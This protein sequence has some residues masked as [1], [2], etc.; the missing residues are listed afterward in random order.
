MQ[1]KYSIVL[2]CYNEFKN[3]RLLIPQ[4]LKILK[5]KKYEIICVDDNSKDHT[6][7]K[8]KKFLK[9]IIKLVLS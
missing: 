4:L 8:L 9:V 7:P 5:K 3:L 6:V 1:I 2:P